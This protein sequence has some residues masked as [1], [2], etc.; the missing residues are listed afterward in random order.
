MTTLIKPKGY[1][2]QLDIKET[3][4]AIKFVR[5]RFEE[6]FADVLNLSRVSS[7]LF[8][9]PETGLNDNL[10]GKENA[11]SFHVKDADNAKV[12]IVHSLA[13]WKRTALN[14]YGYE[15]GEGIYTNMNA[16]RAEEELSNLHSIYVDQWDWEKIITEEE[17]TEQQLQ[18]VVKKIFRIFQ[19]IEWNL[20]N[21]YAYIEPIL[22]D[23]ISFISTQELEDRYPHLTPKERENEIAKEKKA[24]FI[25]QIGGPLHSGNK[26]DDRSP[27][28][29]D[30]TL[31]GDILFWY[32]VLDQAIEMS[33]MGIRVDQ[34]ALVRQLKEADCEDRL[35]LDYH[36]MVL[37]NELPYTI[38]GG[39]GQS[40]ACLFL[41][42]KA[43]IGEVQASVWS[44]EIIEECKSSGIQLL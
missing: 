4:K 20:S 9:Q 40:R 12:E 13:K 39:I 15:Y 24:V 3:E 28:Y 6:K 34:A 16:I 32:P 10:S 8:L 27:D 42:R 38:G 26:H 37:G 36:K 25:T 1:H 30:W 7:P 33:S 23:E 14:D 11:V 44:K 18:Q 43:H 17:R 21:E 22:P 2:S 19:E 31:N 41:L 5:Q 35:T 29:D